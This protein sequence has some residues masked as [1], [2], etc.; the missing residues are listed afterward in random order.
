MP[1]A[2]QFDEYGGLDVLTVREI[3]LPELGK[4]DVRVEVRAAGINPGEASIRK[5][6]LHDRWPATFPSGQGS[7]L[8]GVV[9]EVGIDVEG[10][11]PGDEVL[12]WS[13]DRSSQA[14]EVVV[15]A[16]QLIAKPAD[17][18]WE[19][20]GA[21]HVVG[22]TAFAA[23]RAVDISAG[24]TVVVS[25]AAGGVGTVVV[26]L[27]KVRGA[28]VVG[29]ASEDHHDWLRA[30]GVT[31]VTYGEGVMGRILEAT[32][33]GIDAFIDLFGP[34]YVELAVQLD[35][36]P[37]KIETIIAYEKA[38]EVGAKSEGSADATSPEVLGEMAELV[39]LGKIEIPIAATYP[40]D[41]VREAFQQLEDRHTLGKIVLVP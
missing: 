12:G 33:D 27:L 23:V 3:E 40:L 19:A 8:A 16:E 41:E 13:W 7:D 31:P 11:A 22:V 36:P 21:L 34:E 29:L 2:V 20:A 18:S 37:A 10:F 26:Q 39:A 32:P 17:L 15:P 4:E 6:L 25:A 38:Q 28:N 5:G 30:K 35:V 9:A 14:E 1:R 24:D